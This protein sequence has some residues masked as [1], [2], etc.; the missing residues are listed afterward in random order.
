MSRVLLIVAA[1][2]LLA[3]TGCFIFRPNA[4]GAQSSGKATSSAV[5]N[6]Q[7]QIDASAV[8]LPAGYRIE[9]L[10]TGLTYPT[11]MTFDDQGRI[12]ITE[13]GYCYREDFTTPRLLRLDGKNT[14]EIA[15]GD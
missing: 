3:L 10:A 2:F 9:A 5:K 15:R 7:R 11:G 13:A 8:A 6:G 12:Y 14:V 4:G 1:S